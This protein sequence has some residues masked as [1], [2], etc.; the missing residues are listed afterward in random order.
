MSHDYIG[1]KL[2][3]ALAALRDVNQS[4][5][6]EYARLIA[7]YGV[8]E[9]GGRRFGELT[10]TLREDAVRVLAAAQELADLVVHPEGGE[11][12]R[13]LEREAA[14]VRREEYGGTIVVKRVPCGKQCGGCPHGPY[15]YRVTRAE[16][17]RGQRWTYL[18]RAGPYTPG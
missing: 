3:V 11:E 6:D 2:K 18:G 12:R 16:G 4:L 1:K 10:A 17:G 7:K 14:E 8:D 9:G 13:A 15:L 5:A